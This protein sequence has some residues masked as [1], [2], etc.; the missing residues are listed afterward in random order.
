MSTQNSQISTQDIAV[1]K[2]IDL[3]KLLANDHGELAS[4][5]SACEDEGFFY[6]NLSGTESKD[7]WPQTQK[8]FAVMQE[9]FD[10]PLEDKLKF[11]ATKF[12]V[13]EING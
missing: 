1:L 3:S 7:M 12:G 8:I 11:E 9:Y 5:L 2:T 13:S 6:L 4:L 10:Q